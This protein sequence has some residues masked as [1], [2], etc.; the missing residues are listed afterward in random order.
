MPMKYDS[1]CPIC[2]KHY[3][4]RAR[5]K[6]RNNTP[7]CCGQPTKRVIVPPML[8]ASTAKEYQ[9]Y[10]CPHSG[11]LITSKKTRREVMAKHNLVEAEPL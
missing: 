10:K 6:D 8:Q 9:A 1:E 5:I 3:E 7:E 2:G 4:Y 11:D